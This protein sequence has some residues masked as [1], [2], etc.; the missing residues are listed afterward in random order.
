MWPDYSPA[1][2]VA[3]TKAVCPLLNQ[4]MG[5]NCVE[6]CSSDINCTNRELCCSNGCGRAC[7]T[8]TLIPFYNIPPVCPETNIRDLFRSCDITEESCSM[9]SDCDDDELCC[10]DRCGRRC[11]DTIT[12]STPCFDVVNQIIVPL[13]GSNVMY[14]PSCDSDGTFSPVQCD[15]TRLCWCVDVRNG[16]PVSSYSPRGTRPQCSGKRVSLK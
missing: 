6:S 13:S 14:T 15:A 7:M 8:P 9:R 11:K 12:S 10:R 1:L 5:G 16:R 2:P 3:L 4:S